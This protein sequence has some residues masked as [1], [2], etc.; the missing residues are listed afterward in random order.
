MAKERLLKKIRSIIQEE[1]QISFDRY[2][3]L[4]LYD[5]EEGYYSGELNIGFEKGDYYTA[6]HLHPLFGTLVAKQVL[7]MIR[8]LGEGPCALIELGAGKG[9]LAYDVLSFLRKNAGEAFDRLRYILVER[10][11]RMRELQE[12]RL[13]P[14]KEK[15]EWCADLSAMVSDRVR[16]CVLSNEF[17]DALPVHRLLL[18]GDQIQE[19]YVANARAGFTEVLGQVSSDLLRQ[20]VEALEFKPKTPTMIEVNLL[21]PRWL[22]AIARSLDRGFVITIDYG[23]LAHDL[24]SQRRPRGTLLCYYRHTVSED[25]YERVG[26]QDITSHV[27]FTDLI[28]TGEQAGMGTVGFSDQ[29][30]F[31]MGLGIAQEMERIVSQGAATAQGEREFLALKQLI[32]PAGMGRVFKVLVQSKN[33]E[34]KGLAGMTYRPFFPEA[35]TR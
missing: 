27:N 12:R 26:E 32:D 14:W 3:D 11:A 18:R 15:I 24:Y 20:K 10:S 16:G 17:F 5:P 2:M 7:E 35:I 23:H 9:L 21:A 33:I 6:P 30:H 28:R 34:G 1:G 22:E 4:A 25:P 31:L 29:T 19:I 8:L 13:S